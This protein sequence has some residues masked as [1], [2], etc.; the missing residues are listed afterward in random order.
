MS[1]KIA[2]IDSICPISGD[3]RYS[4]LDEASS[5]N[6][7]RLPEQRILR[8][9][10]SD[11]V[12]SRICRNGAQI[13]SPEEF[14]E[15]LSLFQAEDDERIARQS[16]INEQREEEQF[17]ASLTGIRLK[18]Y[19]ELS[20]EGTPWKKAASAINDEF[21]ARYRAEESYAGS[22]VDFNPHLGYE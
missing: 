15:F 12:V 18:I 10:K 2:K 17:Y 21:R 22:P 20:L 14:E 11:E 9:C 13:V 7:R 6:G 16:A 5:Q 3:V 19:N 8:N 1:I 4:I